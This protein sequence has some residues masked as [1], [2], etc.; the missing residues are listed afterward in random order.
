MVGLPS[1]H[2][3]GRRLPGLFRERLVGPGEVVVHVVET[4]RIGTTR[5]ASWTPVY[6]NLGGRAAD[7]AS[8]QNLVGIHPT[9]VS[10]HDPIWGVQAPGP[11]AQRPSSSYPR[12]EHYAEVALSREG[13]CWRMVVSTGPTKMRHP[14][15]CHEPVT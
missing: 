12:M 2:G 1:S 9:T 6:S 13:E 7:W 15:M 4:D 3:R 5:P 14:D 11:C 10:R 8:S